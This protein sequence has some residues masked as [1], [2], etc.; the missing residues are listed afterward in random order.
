MKS[1]IRSSPSPRLSCG[2]SFLIFGLFIC[3]GS[4]AATS[5]PTPTAIDRGLP[6]R[7][8]SRAEIASLVATAEDAMAREAWMEAATAWSAVEKADPRQAAASYNRGVAAFR[9]GELGTSAEAFR[10]AATLGNA[11]LAAR[12]M[13]NEGT[14]PLRRGLCLSARPPCRAGALAGRGKGARGDPL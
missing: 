9:A 2:R 5:P 12:A 4:L 10:Q 14:R 6:N 13:Y 11:E 7:S 3:A 1:L 8:A